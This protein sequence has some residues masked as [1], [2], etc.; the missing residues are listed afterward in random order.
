[1]TSYRLYKDFIKGK[2]KKLSPDDLADLYDVTL[3]ITKEYGF[4][5]YE[6]SNFQRNEKY[7]KHNYGYWSGLDYL[8]IVLWILLLL[9]LKIK[10]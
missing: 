9:I 2:F 4:K 1:M 6:V 3:E 7:S 10:N 5:Q 8:G